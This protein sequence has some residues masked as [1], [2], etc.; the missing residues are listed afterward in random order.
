V[1]DYAKVYISMPQQFLAEVDKTAQEE[2]L[3]R[4]ALIREAVKLYFAARARRSR[5]RF[6]ELT[7]SLRQDFPNRS[8]EEVEQRIDRAVSRVR[9]RN[10]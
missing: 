9:G 3:S 4:S 10:A 8:D 1:S 2:H 6:F 5:P 7:E